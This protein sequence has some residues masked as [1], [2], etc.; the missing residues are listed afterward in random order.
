MPFTGAVGSWRKLMIAA[1]ILWAF[2]G[3]ALEADEP[4]ADPRRQDS[5]PE[6][7]P[8]PAPRGDGEWW[9]EPGTAVRRSSGARRKPAG[10]AS[11]PRRSRL[12]DLVVMR[13]RWFQGQPAPSTAGTSTTTGTAG[14]PSQV[15]QAGTPGGLQTTV[16]QPAG[17]GATAPGMLPTVSPVPTPLLLNNALGFTDKPYRVY[18]WIENSF[19]GNANGVPRNGENFGVFP[20]HQADRWMGNQY[21]L[22]IENPLNSV[23]TVN[24]GFRFD[25]LFG[26]DWEFTKDYGLFDHAFPNNHFAG[27]DLPQIYAEVHLPILTPRGLDIR[28]GRFFS[29]TGFESPQAIARPLLSV[30]YSMNFTP[31]TFFGAY[32]NLHVHERLN[33]FSG[34][35][36]GF[37]RWPNEPYKWGYIGG[38]TW[39]SRD[40]ETQSGRRRRGCQRP[41]PAVPPGQRHR[42][43]GRGARAGV[44]AR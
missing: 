7:K 42:S 2:P 27:L 1:A 14:V 36:D 29:L 4:V 16:V 12:V 15:A 22:T 38:F 43:A 9:S 33:V 41:A 8:S 11:E 30:P 21:Y 35:V 13:S 17:P 34:T 19:T 6:S 32:A 40:R 20:N 3:G 18:G 24:F 23:D 10:K 44:P 28:A 5:T 39:T 26:N 25:M 37:D 31:F